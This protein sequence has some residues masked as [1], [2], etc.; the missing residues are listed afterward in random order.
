MSQ[1]MN[2]RGRRKSSGEQAQS[3]TYRADDIVLLQRKKEK[4]T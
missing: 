1:T 3:V 4:A 2:D